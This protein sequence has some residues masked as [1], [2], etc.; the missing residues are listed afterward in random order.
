MNKYAYV[1]GDPINL[2]DP[3]GLDPNCGPGMSWDGEGCTQGTTLNGAAGSADCWTV[4]GLD[5]CDSGTAENNGCYGGVNGLLGAPDPGCPAGGGDSGPAPAPPPTITLQEIDDC[6]QPHGTGINPGVWT[7]HVEYQ[8][9]VNGNPV[10]GNSALNALGIV[11]TESVAKTSGN[12][13]ITGG[14]GWCPVG[15]NCGANAGTMNSSGDFWDMLAGQGTANQSFL[16]NGQPIAVSFGGSPGGQTVLNNSYNSKGHN[17]SVGG[18]A[19]IG[20]NKTRECGKNGDPG[21]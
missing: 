16:Y 1:R 13:D 10:Y 14:Q 6:V 2:N 15:G 3:R 17:I 8:V 9:L 19:L 5:G 7:L 20:N 18:G 11:I 4:F 12:I 21:R